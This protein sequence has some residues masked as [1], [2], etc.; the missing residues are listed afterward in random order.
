MWGEAGS[1]LKL[2]AE[3][4]SL[5]TT[6]ANWPEF[7]GPHQS[8]IVHSRNIY[9]PELLGVIKTML[10]SVLEEPLPSDWCLY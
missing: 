10:I 6:Q 9:L 1:A 2:G 4:R 5:F 7:S 3:G 8:Q